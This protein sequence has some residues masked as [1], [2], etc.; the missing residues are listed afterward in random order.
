M[1]PEDRQEPREAIIA[2][3]AR[4]AADLASQAVLTFSSA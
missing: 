3:R 2:M 4:P 1:T